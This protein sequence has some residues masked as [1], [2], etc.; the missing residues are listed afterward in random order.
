MRKFIMKC[1][2]SLLWLCFFGL[3]GIF[4]F[5]LA[6]FHF[7]VVPYITY[8][9]GLDSK[10]FSPLLFLK[11]LGSWTISSFPSSNGTGDVLSGTMVS[12]T[13]SDV[14]DPALEDLFFQ[15][16]TG[17]IS[18]WTITTWTTTTGEDYGFLVPESTGSSSP[19]S[20]EVS[21][22]GSTKQDLL[23]VMQTSEK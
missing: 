15:W 11:S 21:V 6:R 18:S 22:S 9:N 19:F 20:G 2:M 8:L 7:Q 5:W 17:F 16:W 13:Q 23:R 4:L 10:Q 14:Y 3:A 12:G 1:I